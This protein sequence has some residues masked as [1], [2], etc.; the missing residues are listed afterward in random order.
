M[1]KVIILVLSLLLLNVECFELQDLAP[2]NLISSIVRLFSVDISDEEGIAIEAEDTWTCES[3]N[4][5]KSRPKRKRHCRRNSD[6]CYY[7]SGLCY[8]KVRTPTSSPTL[9]PTEN[10]SYLM[11]TSSPTLYPTEAPSAFVDIEE[12][13]PS[14]TCESINDITPNA[15][16]KYKCR[17]QEHCRYKVTE[18][19]CIPNA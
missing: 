19:L 11:P 1:F 4:G 15:K 3:I 13:K 18:K 2:S 8:T 16:R 10:P 14:I 12:L 6:T 7:Y 5:F 9:Y 17:K